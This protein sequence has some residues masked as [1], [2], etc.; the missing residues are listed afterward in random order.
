MYRVNAERSQGKN[1]RI[2]RDPR[3]TKV[4]GRDSRKKKVA[5]RSHRNF[6]GRSPRSCF[7]APAEEQHF[8][9]TQH[10]SEL[11]K[12]RAPLPRFIRRALAKAKNCLKERVYGRF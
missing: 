8:N 2:E 6:A 7:G 4:T 1:D 10:R 12:W 3:Y 5:M 9:S 11:V